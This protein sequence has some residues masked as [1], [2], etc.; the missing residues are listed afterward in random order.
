M[1]KIDG[2]LDRLPADGA[3]AELKDLHQRITLGERF[4][5]TREVGRLKAARMALLAGDRA[6]AERHLTALTIIEPDRE[7]HRRRLGA[8]REME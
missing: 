7:I 5:H 6:A 2:S 4:K 8:L 1:K 3:V